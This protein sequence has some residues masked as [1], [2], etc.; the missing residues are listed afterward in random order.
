MSQPESETF[1]VDYGAVVRRHWLIVAACLLLG[2]AA[3]LVAIA[4]GPSDYESTAS[5]I[6]QP[7]GD[8]T[9]VSNGRTTTS[10]NLDTEAQ[11]VTSLVV[12]DRASDILHSDKSA[13][14]LASH[15]HVGVP[16]NTSVLNITFRDSTPEGAQ[17]G[18]RAFAQAYLANRQDLAE[19]RIAE[20]ISSIR[21]TIGSLNEQLRRVTQQLATAIPSDKDYLS[22]QRELIVQQVRSNTATLS[23]LLTQD[24]QPGSV[25]TD[26]QRP[27]TPSG[28]D[29]YLILASGAFVGLLI[30]V[31]GALTRHR[32][33][34]R[35]RV[36]EDLTDLGLD[37]LVG[38][39]ELPAIEDVLR[40]D[41]SRDE[42][43]RRCRNA[44]L[45]RLP[46]HRGSL[47]VTSTSSN[48]A[49]SAA[50]AS[51]A[52]TLARSGVQTVFVCSNTKRD[53]V[54]EAFGVVT[55]TTLSDVLR[56]GVDPSRALYPLREVPNLTLVAP[57]RDEGLFSELLQESTIRPVLAEL[58]RNFE[59]VILDVAPTS[60][61]ADAQTVVPATEGM[62]LVATLDRSTK[63]EV[64]DAMEQLAHVG[65]PLLGGM[66]VR[67]ARPT[68][69]RSSAT[70]RSSTKRTHREGK[71]KDKRKR[72]GKG[73]GQPTDAVGGPDMPIGQTGDG[74]TDAP[75]SH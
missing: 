19:R 14:G 23:P 6:V 18:A 73:K 8:D 36:R 1:L 46:D 5:V 75:T 32:R 20:R 37:V 42:P 48:G 15:V 55:E 27:T 56:A 31:A 52:V 26:A 24:V 9:N 30:G 10:I 39:F 25:I 22:T 64:E 60:D 16:A 71:D 45:A 4:L 43:M 40:H 13:R 44:L 58:E 35:V 67:V 68:A 66:F 54:H 57:G 34:T 49:G 2:I 33:D 38:Q 65:A 51:L 72:K 62:V 74:M 47:V 41:L 69:R 28:I 61:N 59:V 50:A 29:P 53:T 11:I 17:A 3:G 21:T 70:S 12:A 7:T 63:D